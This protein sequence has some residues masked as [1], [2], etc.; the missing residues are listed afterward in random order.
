MDLQIQGYS[1]KLRLLRRAEQAGKVYIMPMTLRRSSRRIRRQFRDSDAVRG[2]LF[3]QLA[4][5][6][7]SILKF[8][9]NSDQGHFI[10][11]ES[12][13]EYDAASGIAICG[14]R[15]L[16][17]NYGV[18]HE[19]FVHL[20]DHLLGSNG[21]G[22]RMSEGSGITTKIAGIGQQIQEL[23]RSPYFVS[24]YAKENE[25]EYLAQGVR[26]F[27]TQPDELAVSDIELYHFIA[28]SFMN[29]DFWQEVFYHESD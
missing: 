2:E 3:R 1:D 10:V 8:F 15:Y 19:E 12:G 21:R 18:C 16:V 14:I 6:P 22:R 11:T 13:A 4:V 26:F 17:E 9:T 7:L 28:E 24:E 27:L 29:E 25:R 5:F 20:L 23:F